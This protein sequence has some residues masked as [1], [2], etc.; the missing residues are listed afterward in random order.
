MDNLQYETGTSSDVINHTR[1]QSQPSDDSDVPFP[2]PPAELSC[3][4]AY[5]AA[6]S[7]DNV[8]LATSRDT[9]QPDSAACQNHVKTTGAVLTPTENHR[10]VTETVTVNDDSANDAEN[11]NSML[12]LIRKGVTLRKTLTNDRSAPK[13]N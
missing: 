8:P 9:V 11:M 12:A 10:V 6:I 7:V 3:K 5:A 4:V 1:Q 2:S 13:L